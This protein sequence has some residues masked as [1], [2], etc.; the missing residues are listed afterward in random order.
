MKFPPVQPNAE[1]PHR[2]EVS[3]VEQVLGV[4]RDR[5]LDPAEVVRRLQTYGPN[6]IHARGG[7]P[8]WLRI[9]R[10][11]HQPLVYI[12]IVA[13]GLAAW[14]GEPVDAAVILGVVLANA[15]VGFFQ[16][17]KA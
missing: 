14:L 4:D 12:L 17:S 5:G 11:F 6:R 7:A 10:Q 3:E 15:A 16:E 13:G 8:V 2:L 1:T 9:F